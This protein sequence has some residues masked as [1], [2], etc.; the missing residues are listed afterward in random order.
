[1]TV[2]EF[3]D[4]WETY[5]ANHSE[6]LASSQGLLSFDE[7]EKSVWLTAAQSSF[8]KA[9]YTG[10]QSDWSFEKTE[11]LRRSLD[12]LVISLKVKED[13]ID[14]NNLGFNGSWSTSQLCIDDAV[15][16]DES[17]A[18]DNKEI[19][20]ITFEL[21][22]L[23]DDDGNEIYDIPVIPVTQDELHRT[24]KN[25]FRGTSKRRVLR[26][27]I[28]NNNIQLLL[29]KKENGRYNVSEYRFRGIRKPKPIILVSLPDGLAIDGI[30]KVTNCELNTLTHRPILEMAVK[31]AVASRIQGQQQNQ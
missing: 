6:S 25:P 18:S 2:N 28:G 14:N 19:W 31:M 15:E 27:D 7:Y 9:L 22:D 1:M 29:P 4:E 12:A 23:K 13:F 5:I 16:Y 24:L 8:I 26:M 3:S 11:E 20:F 17:S 30:D 10:A 21:C